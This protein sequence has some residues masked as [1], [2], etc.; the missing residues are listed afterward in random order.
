MRIACLLVAD[1]PLAVCR[2]VEPELR[3]APYAVLRGEGSRA[4]VVACSPEAAAYGARPGMSA[5][6]ARAVC[7]DMIFRPASEDAARAAAQA[8]YDVACAHSPRVEEGTAGTVF[9][10]IGGMDALYASEPEL[11][12]SLVRCAAEIGF[13]AAAGV[14]SSKVA[15]RLAACGGSGRTVIPPGDE[16]SC[17]APLPLALLEPEPPLA[18]ALLRWGIRTLG[19]L[20][21]LPA[22]ALATRL[23][24]AA[25]LLVRRARGEDE[26]PFVPRPPRRDFVEVVELDHG[27]ESIEPFLFVARA[28]LERLM[29]RLGLRG[30]VCGDL[31]LAL[32]LANRG[33]DERRVAVAAPGRE[34]K[35]LLTLLRLHLEAHPPA[36]PVEKISIAATAERLRPLQL[37]LLRPN[38]PA[39]AQLAMTLARLTALCGGAERVGA[40][41][42]ADSHRPDAY[43]VGEFAAT[44]A[45]AATSAA[46]VSG[47]RLPIALRAL[48]P[49]RELEVVIAPPAAC[50]A[51]VADSGEEPA[52]RLEFVRCSAPSTTGFH[53]HGRVVMSAG[54]WREQGEWW[55][56]QPYRRDY[57]DV[58]LSDGA[59]YRLFHDAASGKWFVDG[60]YD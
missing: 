45:G 57:Y 13:E 31:H 7:A 21:A 47:S 42:V 25:A 39:P 32:R 9:L 3:G 54:P 34:V 55:R 43:A 46:A 15:A 11:A 40:P 29:A 59:V 16:W 58:Q 53:C 23:G 2:R 1:F 5:A 28:M 22:A 33:R 51:S 52:G 35:P 18:A 6:Q 56:E 49:P 26:A 17:L 41:L 30:L 10:E 50:S 19:E 48:R 27:I 60:W 4:A 14:A 36:S 8:L 24:P 12:R 20:A 38:G 44:A 37:D